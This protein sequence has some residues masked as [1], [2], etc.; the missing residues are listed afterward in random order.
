MKDWEQ[1]LQTKERDAIEILQSPGF[2]EFPFQSRLY[3]EGIWTK[4][5]WALYP[6]N[7]LLKNSEFKKDIPRCQLETPNVLDAFTAFM[8]HSKIADIKAWITISRS[9]KD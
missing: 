5:T 8:Q 9:N 2:L 7:L 4:Q 3:D 1:G 6:N